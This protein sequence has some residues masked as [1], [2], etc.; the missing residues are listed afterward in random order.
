MTKAKSRQP[1]S[2]KPSGDQPSGNESVNKQAASNRQTKGASDGN[3][4]G[5]QGG[6]A[7]R[8]SPL[9]V[10][11][12]VIAIAALGGIYLLT[13]A[14]PF[15][16][17]EHAETPIAEVTAQVPTPTQLASNP[18]T[19]SPPSA[20]TTASM[21]TTAARPTATRR[22][23]SSWWEVYFTDPQTINDPNNLKGS[24]PEKLIEFID[25]AEKSIHIAAF[26]FNLTPV[27]E[28]LIRAH[29]RGVEVQW[30]TD[31]EYGIARDKEPG[32]GQFAMLRKAGIKVQDDGRT[33][34]MHNK[35]WIFDEKTV[36]TGSTN[37]TENGNFRN[38]NNVLVLHSPEVA[39][40][41][42]TEF[43]EMWRKN[44]GPT[45]PS[46]V[47]LQQ[48]TV[49]RTPVQV[50]FAPEDKVISRLIPLVE[51][52][53]SSIHFMAFSFTHVELGAAMRARAE[54]GVDVRGIFETRASET[55]HSELSTLY[56]AQVPVR[57]DGN[58]G[59]FHHKVIVIDEE[60]VITGSLNFSAN[61]DQS[62]DEN[63]VV[64]TSRSIASQYLREFGRRWDEGNEPN[65]SSI[66][67]GQ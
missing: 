44:F 6:T 11:L 25:A 16:L 14:D 19:Q 10:A 27:A 58:P 43:T 47:R 67:C 1:R 12:V 38:N 40:I 29:Q 42:E 15:Q 23:S 41:F 13:G 9:I 53:Q 59:A 21:P 3:Q 2:S 50:L 26:E 17:F 5:T 64:I 20:P 28:A 60:T 37:I 33:A 52:A 54:A 34:L 32:R 56:C 65:P 66:Q 57:Q 22:T 61:A 55:E 18:T 4:P 35:F 62:N 7:K 49:N 63:V 36:W 30:V 39:A 48:T 8:R 46:S 24:I 31:D 51:N 45:S